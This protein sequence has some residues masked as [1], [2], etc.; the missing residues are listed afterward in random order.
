MFRR[1]RAVTLGWCRS[2]PLDVM[3]C[4]RC[5]SCFAAAALACRLFLAAAVTLLLELWNLPWSWSGAAF[6]NA[7]ST[8]VSCAPPRQMKH[9]ERAGLTYWMSL[10]WAKLATFSWMSEIQTEGVCLVGTVSWKRFPFDCP[11]LAA[12]FTWISWKIP[13]NSCTWQN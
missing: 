6:L 2:K 9:W 11:L 13:P 12:M 7:P 5:Y 3:P 1:G 10:Y 4:L 8:T